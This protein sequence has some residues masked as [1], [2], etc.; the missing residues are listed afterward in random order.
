MGEGRAVS[1]RPRTGPKT[2]DKPGRLKPGWAA[3]SGRAPSVA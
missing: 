3:A 2:G 1:G